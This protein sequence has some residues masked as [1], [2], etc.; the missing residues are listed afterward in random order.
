M[1]VVAKKYRSCSAEKMVPK[2][3]PNKKRPENNAKKERSA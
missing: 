2:I 3:A 1:A